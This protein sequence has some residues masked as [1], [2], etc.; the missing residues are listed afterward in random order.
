MLFKGL[1]DCVLQR[2]R[3]GEATMKEEGQLILERLHELLDDRNQ[4]QTSSSQNP[5]HV[6]LACKIIN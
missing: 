2:H 3:M 4:S 6:R 1:V 5:E